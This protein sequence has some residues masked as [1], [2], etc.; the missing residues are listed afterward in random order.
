MTIYGV[1]FGT[2]SACAIHGAPGS[3]SKRALALPR[4]SGG[5]TKAM[6]FP[7]VLEALMTGNAAVPAGDVVVESAT[8]GA[9]GCE[10]SDVMELLKR[11]PERS[12]FTLSCRAVKNHRKD[13]D[14]EWAKGARYAKDGTTPPPVTM[15]LE[16]QDT[17][18][19]EDARI[20]YMIAT[21]H[22]ERL[23]K[24]TQPSYELRRLHTSV[25]PMDKRDYRD[26]RAERYMAMLPAFDSLPADLR[27]V[28]GIHNGSG[29]HRQLVYSRAMVMPFAMATEEPHLEDG[30]PEE[31][32]GRFEKVIGMYDRGY[33]SFYRRAVVEWMQD[34]AKR[35]AGVTKM[36]EVPP[37]VRKEAWKLTQRQIRQFYHLMMTH[38]GK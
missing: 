16:E 1:D 22:P 18:H 35:L 37:P 15:A 38:Q 10:P 3:V 19:I 31:R 23:Y 25:R 9:S 24:W 28:F 33:P 29:A 2:G 12:L 27:E 5:R 8:I 26:E 4:V 17:V 7:M 36:E 32:R 30:P 34:N 13:H 20:I 6:E 21:E 14:L 11:V